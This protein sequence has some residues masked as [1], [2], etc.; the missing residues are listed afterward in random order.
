MSQA[1]VFIEKI[2]HQAASSKKNIV[3]PEATEKRILQASKTI[4]ERGIA[5]IILIGDKNE[6]QKAA[7]EVALDL[8]QVRIV[9]PLTSPDFEK[10]VDRYFEL[11]HHKN[12]T[13]GEATEV[14]KKPIF[15]GTMMVHMDDADG[16]VSGSIHSTAA[17]IKPALQ[18]IKTKPD[19]S[20]VSSIFF[21]VIEDR[22]LVFG[23]CAIVEYPTPEEL[24]EIAVESAET[25]M[26]FGL[27]P[28]V[29]MLSYSTK[30]SA[31]SLSPK[32]VIEATKKAQEIILK[33][34]GESAKIIIDG[35]LQ[36]DAAL[37]ES[38]AALK[39]PD[40]PVA[41]K[42]NVLIFP[43]LDAGNIG[44]KLV[45]RLAC[46]HAYGPILQGLAKPVNDL[47]RGCSPSDIVGIT[48]I[49]VVQSQGVVL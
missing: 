38:V 44:Y 34:Y 23:D 3:F 40:S 46:A 12:I 43:N 24:A 7:Q 25:A 6:V 9:D 37:V 32:K 41:G 1:K 13:M 31:P 39:C 17:T 21:M 14:M 2:I 5:S 15:F 47:S 8:D 48:A 4:I 10:Y 20:K 28:S 29:A 33:K 49:T 16:L 19:L 27:E 35:E 42:A 30:G 36:G 22:V 45:E 11:R 18:I 26:L